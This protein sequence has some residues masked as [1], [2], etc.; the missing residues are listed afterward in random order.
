MRGMIFEHAKENERQHAELGSRIAESEN[1][2]LWR[3]LA[4]MAAIV[5][6]ATWLDRV[7]G[8]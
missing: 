6:L 1:R 8:G 2:L 5:G 7:V 4:G 3:M